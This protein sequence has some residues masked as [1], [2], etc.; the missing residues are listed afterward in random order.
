[1]GLSTKRM[2][3]AHLFAPKISAELATFT[4][5]RNLMLNCDGFHFFTSG[6]SSSGAHSFTCP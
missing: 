4:T 2:V 1:M 6:G 5:R 3:L